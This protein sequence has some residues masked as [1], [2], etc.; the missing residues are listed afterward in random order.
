MGEVSLYLGSEAS[1]SVVTDVD[2]RIY[3]LSKE[4]FKKMQ[5]EAPEKTTMLHS[6]V[7]K[8]LSDRLAESNATI[9]AFMR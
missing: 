2:C 5:L 1:A 9:Q 7:V 8:L 4:N 3:Y 6:Y